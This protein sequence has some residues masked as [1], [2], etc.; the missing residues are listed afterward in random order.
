MV[1][2]KE[3]GVF[4]EE[5]QIVIRV[6]SKV[7]INEEYINA[8]K[9]FD[10]NVEKYG[11]ESDV[12]KVECE[13]LNRLIEK[14]I[15]KDDN[16][17]RAAESLRKKGIEKLLTGIMISG[18]ILVLSI[19]IYAVVNWVI[20]PFNTTA[21]T[22][23]MMVS[24]NIATLLMILLGIPII[25]VISIQM[26]FYYSILRRRLL[27]QNV[28]PLYIIDAIFFSRLGAIIIHLMEIKLN[29][30]KIIEKYGN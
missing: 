22:N 27:N 20:F 7:K 6:S 26:E 14:I 29:K 16:V 12:F 21:G 4:F 30:A 25:F 24:I 9:Q 10:K 5:G 3:L 2:E 17:K 1:K 13:R 8:R 11:V 23:L 15:A 18:I 28:A 19:V